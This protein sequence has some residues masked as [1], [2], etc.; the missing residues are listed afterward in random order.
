MSFLGNIFRGLLSFGSAPRASRAAATG[1]SEAARKSRRG[2]SAL[3]MTE[4]GS[5][6]E[7]LQSDKVRRSDTLFGN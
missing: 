5:R 3:F 1:L 2:R 4:G 7:E 6:G